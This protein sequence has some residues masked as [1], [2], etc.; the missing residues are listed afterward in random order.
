MPLRFINLNETPHGNFRYKE[1][2]TGEWI[3]GTQWQQLIDRVKA[4]R[5]ANNI[6]IGMNFEEMIEHQVCQNVDPQYCVQEGY[7]NNPLSTKPTTYSQMVQGTAI[8]A[9]WFLEGR[10]RVDD[11]EVDRRS[12]ACVRCNFNIPSADCPSC[13]GSRLRDIVNSVVNNNPRPNDQRLHSCRLCGCALQAKTR[14]PLHILKK[15]EP[16]F[17]KGQYPEW[18]WL[19]DK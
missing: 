11:A 13:A 8:L 12:E 6:P 14:I 9:Q 17:L 1:P 7:G 3:E 18:C 2:E 19:S 16:E 10:E 5:K 15:H 4:H